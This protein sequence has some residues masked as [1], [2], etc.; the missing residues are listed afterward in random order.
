M[1]TESE[2]VADIVQALPAVCGSRR[3]QAAMVAGGL[4]TGL[5][6]LQARSDAAF[7]E[8]A[9]P[10][11]A[12]A[13]AGHPRIGERSTEAQTAA[14][15]D[16]EQAAARSAPAELLAELRA[17]NVDY[18][19]RFGHLFLIAAAG[20]SGAQ[21]LAELRRRLDNGRL[22]ERA[23]VREQLRLIARSRLAAPGIAGGR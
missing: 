18:E 13:L 17:A 12:E 3:W 20:R 14:L 9:W 6:A 5:A 21:I 7:A 23:E 11:L 10:D 15:S 19:R 4:P 1:S 16:R 2:P 8:L 22:A